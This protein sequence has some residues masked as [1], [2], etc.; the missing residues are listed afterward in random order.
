MSRRRTIPPVHLARSAVYVG[1]N[2]GSICYGGR[3]SAPLSADPDAVTCSACRNSGAWQRAKMRKRDAEKAA[4]TAAL[5]S[6]QQ[7][8]MGGEE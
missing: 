2:D 1:R 3:Y 6:A 4:R 5:Q 8:P 7:D